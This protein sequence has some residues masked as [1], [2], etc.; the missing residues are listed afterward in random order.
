MYMYVCIY[1]YIYNPIVASSKQRD[2]NPDK[3]SFMKKQCCKRRMESLI[4]RR[5]L[6]YQAVILRVRVP[7]FA[8][9]LGFRGFRD[10]VFPPA[11]RVADIPGVVLLSLS[12]SSL[13]LS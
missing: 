12:L 1:I 3:N 2:P 9:E 6:S 7:S 13:L 8:S 11:Q 10:E 5:F 4:C